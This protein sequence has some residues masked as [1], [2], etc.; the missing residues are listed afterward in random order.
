MLFAL[1][2]AECYYNNAIFN[3]TL[4]EERQYICHLT[5]CTKPTLC[6][7][8][9]VLYY[10]WCWRQEKDNATAHNTT[11]W[12][13]MCSICLDASFSSSTDSLICPPNRARANLCPPSRCRNYPLSRQTGSHIS[14][15]FLH[16]GVA[17]QT[18]ETAAKIWPAGGAQGCTSSENWV[19]PLIISTTHHHL[20][21]CLCYSL[22]SPS[23]V[24]LCLSFSSIFPV[25]QFFPIPWH[26]V[27]SCHL[28]SLSLACQG[29]LNNGCRWGFA[30]EATYTLTQSFSTDHGQAWSDLHHHSPYLQIPS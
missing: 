11:L 27:A 9:D 24:I 13:E 8:I 21:L 4:R 26:C 18:R 20:S 14:S 6:V 17:G 15:I 16:W 7:V 3:S 23:E 28:R 19:E 22:L 12:K 29:F 10:C 25:H 5:K 2:P 1:H 30:Y